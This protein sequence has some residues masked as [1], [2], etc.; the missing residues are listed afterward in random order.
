MTR[1]RRL[2]DMQFPAFHIALRGLCLS[3][4]MLFFSCDWPGAT[5]PD[6][7]A[8][9]VLQMQLTDV[10]QGLS[11]LL[12]GPHG[13][14]LYDCGDDSAGIADTLQARGV[15]HLTTVVIS[16]FH[17][18]HAGGFI[19]L[20]QAVAAGRLH[21]GR[22]RLG[23]DAER[24]PWRDSLF[25]YCARLRIPLD[26][27]AR[28]D[29]LADLAPFSAR[30]LWPPRDPTQRL[31]NAASLVLRVSDGERQA[32]LMGDLESGGEDSLLTYEPT[33]QA[34]FLQV[35]H[36]GSQSSSS[37]A[38]LGRL[39]PAYAWISAGRHNDYGHPHAETLARLYAVLPD[40]SRLLRSDRQGS[41]SM[42]WQY[43]IGAWPADF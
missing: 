43:G 34:F 7:A 14:V 39:Q 30:I 6:T 38:F 11:V 20:A 16:H 36:H 17:R 5:H 18:D 25:A 32:W 15:D 9:A 24:S 41:L 42:H 19:P 23:Y 21:I 26:T 12:S 3:W 27:L 37:W 35:G 31:G 10:G 22:V 1:E 4:T 29:T 2:I 8:N 13:Q 33:A 28:G 40:S